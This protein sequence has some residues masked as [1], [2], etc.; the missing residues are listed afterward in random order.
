MATIFDGCLSSS[1]CRALSFVGVTKIPAK[2]GR[3]CGVMWLIFAV[4][5][6]HI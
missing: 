1:V 4:S 2:K 5:M 6:L 3:F